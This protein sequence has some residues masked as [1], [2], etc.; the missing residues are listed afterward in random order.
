MRDKDLGFGSGAG[1][2]KFLE[3][4]IFLRDGRIVKCNLVTTWDDEREE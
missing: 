2:V 4:E 3:E 1:T